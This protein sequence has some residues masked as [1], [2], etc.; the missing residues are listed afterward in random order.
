[1]STPFLLTGVTGGLGARILNDMLHTHLV[2]PANII[3]TS[4]SESNRRRFEAQ[5]VKFRV[6]DYGHPDTLQTAFE[7]V[8]NLLFVSSSERDT[9]KRNSEHENVVAAAKQK[10]VGRVWYVSLALGG[11]G[12]GSRVGFQQAHYQTEEMLK[13]SGINFISLRAGVY[14]DAFPLFLNWYPSS[15]KVLLPRLAPSVETGRVAWTSRDELGEGIAALLAKGL[16][17]FPSIKP[18]TDKN[19]ILLTGQ[20]AESHVT[21][22]DAI[23]RARGTDIPI[24]LWETQDLVEASA[25]DDVGGKPV[26]WFQAR[27]IWFQGI[28]EGDAATTD[29]ALQKLLGRRPESGPETLQRLLKTDSDYTWHQNHMIVGK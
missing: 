13:E 27:V 10:G 23:N 8:E 4:R 6:A 7:R 21:L 3:A 20:V 29:P 19:L 11:F 9:P 26:A 12:S 16:D 24:Q 15:A 14:T 28:C 22:V 2:P 18:Q 1:M 5:G 17:A 25:K